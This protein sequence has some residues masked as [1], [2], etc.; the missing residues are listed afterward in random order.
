MLQWKYKHVVI[1]FRV[2][3]V[4]THYLQIF[5]PYNL[6][7]YPITVLFMT[8]T[9]QHSLEK[10]G[11]SR[12]LKTR[13]NEI[14]RP[15]S[16]RVQNREIISVSMKN[17]RFS[18]TIVCIK[19]DMVYVAYT[20]THI[21]YTRGRSSAIYE[22]H[23]CQCNKIR[24]MYNTLS[25]IATCVRVNSSTL[26]V[27]FE[28]FSGPTPRIRHLCTVGCFFFSLRF[29]NNFESITIIETL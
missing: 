19:C 5:F 28:G 1:D 23:I 7:N 22:K 26:G 27:K 24:K 9:R 17:E 18:R 20:S 21:L 25:T 15:R 16:L 4:R 8:S 10:R 3:I 12:I 13:V 11:A 2:F 6:F 29:L 14:Q